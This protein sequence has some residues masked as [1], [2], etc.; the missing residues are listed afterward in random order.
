MYYPRVLTFV[1]SHI[2]R[3]LTRDSALIEVGRGIGEI[4]RIGTIGTTKTTEKLG[5]QK[6]ISTLSAVS[7][8]LIFPIYSIRPIYLINPVRSTPYFS[9]LTFHFLLFT[10]HFSPFTSPLNKSSV[11]DFCSIF[12]FLIIICTF[13]PKFCVIFV[14]KR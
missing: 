6:I 5:Y 11:A 10:S 1:I 8:L 7:I 9:P 3:L 4:G 14:T 2:S 13:A 12:V